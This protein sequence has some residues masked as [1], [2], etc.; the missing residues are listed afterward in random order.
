[1]ATNQEKVRGGEEEVQ[2]LL[3]LLAASG[4]PR[5]MRRETGSS[6]SPGIS[7]NIHAW[8]STSDEDG[9]YCAAEDGDEEEEEEEKEEGEE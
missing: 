3:S 6:M 7:A 4:H 1:M 2:A 5:H 9:E 8:R